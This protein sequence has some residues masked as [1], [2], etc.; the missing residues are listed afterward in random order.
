MMVSETFKG[1]GP[2]ER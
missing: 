1:H 2:T